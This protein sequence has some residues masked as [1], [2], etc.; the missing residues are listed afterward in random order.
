MA[1]CT[2]DRKVCQGPTRFPTGYAG[3]G[4]DRTSKRPV[5]HT[6]IQTEV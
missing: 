3:L 4:Q 1:D 5:P 2:D 6:D